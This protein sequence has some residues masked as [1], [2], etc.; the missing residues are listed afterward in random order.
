MERL[1]QIIGYTFRNKKLLKQALTHSSYANEKKLG[2]LGCNERL[3]FLGDAVLELVS[4]D[5]LYAKFHQIPEGELTKKKSEPGVR[6]QSCLLRQ[7]V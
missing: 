1:E 7:T 3:E 5:V 4:S 2:K 6:A